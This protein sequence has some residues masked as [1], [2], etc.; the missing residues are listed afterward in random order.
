MDL[1]PDYSVRAGAEEISGRLK[2]ALAEL[3][4]VRGT[5]RASDSVEITLGDAAGGVAAPPAGRELSVWMGYAES[6]L[7]EMGTYWHSETDLEFAPV[8]R[9][10]IRATGADLRAGSPLKAPRTRAWRDTTVGGIVQ[11]IAA[12]NGYSANVDAAIGTTEVADEAQTAESDLHFLRRLAQRYD[13]TARAVG[14]RLVLARAGAGASVSGRSM[15]ALTVSPDAPPI[16]GRV[17]YRERPRYGAVRASW[18]DT[19]GGAPATVTAGAGDPTMDLPDPYPTRAEAEAA[20]RAKLNQLSRQA[21][22]LELTLRG[23]PTLAGGGT[24]VTEGWGDPANGRWSITRA[25]HRIT[26][27]SGYTTEV[28]ATVMP[29]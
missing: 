27:T 8:R 12:D 16:S 9:L 20:A 6:D 3:V 17:A 1:T 13:G 28:T 21:A 5:D 22:T 25:T 7:V 29:G 15:P 4:V 19:A 10:V 24:V 11:Q 14:H 2:A 18:L 26:P 23:T